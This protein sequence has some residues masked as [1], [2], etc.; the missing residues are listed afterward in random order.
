MILIGEEFLMKIILNNYY[1][2]HKLTCQIFGLNFT[3]NNESKLKNFNFEL[4][5]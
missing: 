3:T 4:T 2:I 5:M 1:A